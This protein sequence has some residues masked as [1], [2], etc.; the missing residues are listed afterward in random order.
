MKTQGQTDR[1]TEK[2]QSDL[3]GSLQEPKRPRYI[4]MS[5]KS[6]LE[7]QIQRAASFGLR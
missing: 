6:F 2:G 4:K 3:L 7:I 1:H 5:L